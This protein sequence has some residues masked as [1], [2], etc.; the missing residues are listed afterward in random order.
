[1][2]AS[3]TPSEK[4]PSSTAGKYSVRSIRRRGAVLA[5]VLAVVLG[6]A[7]FLVLESRPPSFTASAALLA[8]QSGPSAGNL[9]IITPSRVDPTVYETALTDG[10]VARAALVRLAGGQPGQHEVD[11]FLRSVKVR[12]QKNDASSVITITA[13]EPTAALAARAANLLA[14]GLVAWDRDRARQTVARSIDALKSSIKDIDAQ[15]AGTG[16]GPDLTAGQRQTLTDLR[17]QRVR[18]LAAAQAAGDSA[19][20]MGLLE[21]LGTAS[22][23]D[24]ADSSRIAFFILIAAV[25]GLILGYGLAFVQWAVD[26]RVRT[27]D[28]LVALVGRPVLAEFPV[29]PNASS[30]EISEAANFLRSAALLAIR[31]PQRAAIAITSPMDNRDKEGVVVSLAEST[32]RAGYR[33]LLVD[34][35]LR[36]PSTN[37]GLELSQVEAPPLEVYLENPSVAYRPAR[38]GIGRKRSYDFVPSF[39]SALYPV[40]LLNRGFGTVL[41]AWR[42]S[43]DVIIVDC[44]PVLPFADTIAIAPLC[45]GLLLCAREG[46]TSRHDVAESLERLDQLNL[47]LVGS[48][49]TSGRSERR[50]SSAV[51]AQTLDPYDTLSPKPGKQKGMTNVTVRQRRTGR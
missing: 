22:P 10:G 11:R 39:T 4:R 48:V 18:Q 28:D 36:K 23:P 46:E 49:L 21:P 19:V 27:R 5:V 31:S 1:M 33:T 43:Y 42:E 50:R 38:I 12:I 6:G 30:Q 51:G 40:E 26:P 16:G 20:A 47:A 45:D 9:K 13:T 44:P 41:D 34:A 15:L 8:S 37:Y 14:D 17:A 35:D 2:S 25:L 7:A 32:A 3:T 24:R 29:G